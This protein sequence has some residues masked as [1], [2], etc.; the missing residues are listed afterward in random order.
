MACCFFASAPTPQNR[1]EGGLLISTFYW[2]ALGNTLGW[3]S[4]PFG[5]RLGRCKQ[6]FGN[7]PPEESSSVESILESEREYP[8]TC[9]KTGSPVERMN[10]TFV[11]GVNMVVLSSGNSRLAHTRQNCYTTHLPI[12]PTIPLQ[13]LEQ[14]DSENYCKLPPK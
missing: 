12:V 7:P 11:L 13:G 1:Q 10:I 3:W 4:S 9:A 14:S 8:T 5:R 6:I 2:K